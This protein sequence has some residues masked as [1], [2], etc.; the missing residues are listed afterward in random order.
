MC[1]I[2]FCILRE[3]DVAQVNRMSGDR[4]RVEISKFDSRASR[5]REISAQYPYR[6]SSTLI[7][8]LNVVASRLCA[9]MWWYNDL[10]ARR[11]VGKMK[12]HQTAAGNAFVIVAWYNQLSASSWWSQILEI[13]AARMWIWKL[14]HNSVYLRCNHHF[15]HTNHQAF[16]LLEYDD[17]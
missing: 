5:K 8:R 14:L 13:D 17:M 12:P 15:D 1:E 11:R 10:D 3:R 6:G 4:G 2:S 16:F 7:S 9:P